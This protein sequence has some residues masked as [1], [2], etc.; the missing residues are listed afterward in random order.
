[1]GTI[2]EFMPLLLQGLRTTLWVFFATA[3]LSI[4]L[5]LAVT[6]LRVSKSPIISGLTQLYILLMRGTPLLLQIFFVFFGL[7]Y[8]GIVLQR[9]HAA[10][11]AFT[12]NYAAYFAEIFRG[13]LVS[14]SD[15]QVEASKVLGIS[16]MDTYVG[17]I[18]P[19]VIKRVLPPVGNELI[20]LVKDTAL[21]YILGLGDVLRFARTASNASASITPFFAAALIYLVL[22]AIVTLLLKF[23][24]G[25]YA[26]Y[27]G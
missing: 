16:R 21:V 24:E 26:Y 2:L 17:I 4:P 12:L 5:G 14:I 27:R 10:V 23:A 13:G 7:P 11:L 6:L 25:R 9:E 18:L 15:G 22:V 3:V 20:T 8:L 19:Q 1:M